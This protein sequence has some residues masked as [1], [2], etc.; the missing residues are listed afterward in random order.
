M[1]QPRTISQV[2]RSLGDHPAGSRYHIKVLEEAGLVDLTEIRASDGYTEKYYRA[3]AKAFIFHKII[4]PTD[5]KNTLVFM[6]S[7]DLALDKLKIEFES[8]I[9]DY[10]MINL[11]VGSLDGLIALRQG[12]TNFSGCHVFD[13]DTKEFNTPL[14]KRLFPE[15][16]IKVITLA[17]REQGL[18]F[19]PGNPKQI[20]GLGDIGR[21]DISIINRNRGSGTRIWFDKFLKDSEIHPGEIN[22]YTQEMNSHTAVAASIK[23]GI[24][25]T[26]LGLIAAATLE[27]LDFIPLFAEQ[28]DLVFHEE[29]ID[30]NIFNSI[31]DILT[32]VECRHTVNS[33][34]GYDS[35]KTGDD[36]NY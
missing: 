7:H 2:S 18:M 19:A 12:I 9:P 16:S 35:S 6:G 10:S 1:E 28:Y 30:Q 20:T 31:M 13:P 24:A 22:G 21:E 8:R 3:V 17:H 36:L 25:D 32:G 34:A 23:S 27:G 14:I 11:P 15:K 29:K 5:Q 4:L 26:G 33:L